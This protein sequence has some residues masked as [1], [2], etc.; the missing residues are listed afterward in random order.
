MNEQLTGDCHECHFLGFSSRDVAIIHLAKV[1]IVAFGHNGSLKECLPRFG[2]TS[3]GAALPSGFAAIAIE[4]GKPH[5]SC[6]F[7]AG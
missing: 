4:R 6:G 5:E 2:S 7:I 3:P 1:G